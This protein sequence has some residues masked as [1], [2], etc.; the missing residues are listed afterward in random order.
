MS[1]IKIRPGTVVDD[2][3]TIPA[4]APTVYLDAATVHEIRPHAA[5][6]AVIDARQN[7]FEPVTYHV[8]G[9]AA[10][11]VAGVTQARQDAHHG[12]H[13]ACE[14]PA[15]EPESEPTNDPPAE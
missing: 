1:F 12:K 15:P 11:V 10:A 13:S 4:D 6:G 7:G 9:T 14:C 2:V 8:K 3:L 5:G